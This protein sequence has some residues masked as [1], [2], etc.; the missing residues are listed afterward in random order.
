MSEA[1]AVIAKVPVL[2]RTAP[3]VGEVIETV[4]GVPS[5]ALVDVARAFSMKLP[6]LRLAGRPETVIEFA[7][8]DGCAGVNI[9]EKNG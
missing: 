8:G 2:A 1:V 7:L 6:C 3:A 9:A 5:V 4:G